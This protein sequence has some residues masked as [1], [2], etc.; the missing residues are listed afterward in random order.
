MAAPLSLEMV[1]SHLKT[2]SLHSWFWQ[3]C[4]VVQLS[5]VTGQVERSPSFPFT[6]SGCLMEYSSLGFP[7][8]F[9][10]HI[11]VAKQQ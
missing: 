7:R 2:A 11:T 3:N 8:H 4:K 5:H 6:E 1:Y 9:L 10:S